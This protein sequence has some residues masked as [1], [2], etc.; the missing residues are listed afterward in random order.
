M[1]DARVPPAGPAPRGFQR[2]GAAYVDQVLEPRPARVPMD[3]LHRHV[4]SAQAHVSDLYF[5]A[6]PMKTPEAVFDALRDAHEAL[7]RARNV[8]EEARQ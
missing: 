3:H 4:L 6:D 7:L 2:T 1:P 5:L 8:L